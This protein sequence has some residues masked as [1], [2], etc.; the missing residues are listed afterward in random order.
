M[1]RSLLSKVLDKVT[2]FLP[3]KRFIK[4]ALDKTLNELLSNELKLEDFKNGELNLTNIDFN[5]AKINKVYLLAS[6]YS[7]HTGSI[8]NL[9]ISLPPLSEISTK[10]I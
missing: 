10:S 8:G 5:V 4:Y 7:M 9:K 1:F 3:V 2:N 6:P